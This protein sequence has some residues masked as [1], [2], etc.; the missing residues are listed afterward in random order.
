[1]SL[2]DLVDRKT[3]VAHEGHSFSVRGLSLEDMVVLLENHSDALA[4]VFAGDNG[5]DFGELI[6][7][8]PLFIAACIAYAADEP[9]LIEQ[10]RRL[11]VG[12]QL[13]AIEAIWELSSLDVET[14]GKLAVSMLNS[15]STLNDESLSQLKSNLTTSSPTTLAQQSS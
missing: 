8:F 11:P 6:K 4:R 15:I 7:E 10:V 3:E 2:R 9:E 14:V 5:T 12:V 1:M 13:R